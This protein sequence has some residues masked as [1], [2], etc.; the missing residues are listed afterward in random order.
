MKRTVISEIST[1]RKEIESHDDE[2]DRHGLKRSALVNQIY[3]IIGENVTE[4][5]DALLWGY[6]KYLITGEMYID[7]HRH[8]KMAECYKK[9]LEIRIQLFREYHFLIPKEVSKRSFANIV[10]NI[11]MLRNYY[12]NDDCDDIYQ[13]AKKS[14]LI[15]RADLDALFQSLENIQK[16]H[17]N[18][19]PIEESDEYLAV[20]DEVNAKA[21]KNMK[22]HGMGSCHEFWYLKSKYLEEKG[23]RWRSPA[24]LNPSVCAHE[25]AS[26][27]HVQDSTESMA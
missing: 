20:I 4:D 1:L 26:A 23:I 11:L 19:D 17:L 6:K 18:K 3:E 10:L 25:N 8:L 21:R 14:R 15:T 7:I 24:V 27:S 12:L 16:R 5:K 13:L 22:H 2:N 9:A